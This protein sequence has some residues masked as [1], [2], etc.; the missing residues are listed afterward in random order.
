MRSMGEAWPGG[1]HCLC[2][3]SYQCDPPLLRP[4]SMM[5]PGWGFHLFGA[6]SFVVIVCGK[7]SQISSYL[8]SMCNHYWYTICGINRL[9]TVSVYFVVGKEGHVHSFDINAKHMKNGKENFFGWLNS[10][11]K[12]KFVQWPENV[13]FQEC[14]VKNCTEK[15]PK[16]CKLDA[17]SSIILVRFFNF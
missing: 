1:M 17:V 15:L 8:K 2:V 10:W 16:N 6:L 4:P 5:Q 3:I 7:N 12:T 11:N 14:T 9:L 13:T